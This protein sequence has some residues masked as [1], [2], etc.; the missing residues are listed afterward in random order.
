MIS[1][2]NIEDKIIN[3]SANKSLNCSK[4]KNFIPKKDFENSIHNLSI[5]NLAGV[6]KSNGSSHVNIPNQNLPLCQNA[7][8]INTDTSS[9]NNNN[10]NSL[11]DLNKLNN[12]N[13]QQIFFPMPLGSPT[14]DNIS[15]T[16]NPTQEIPLTLLNPSLNHNLNNLILPIT[17]NN[18]NMNLNM[19]MNTYNTFPNNNIITPNLPGFSQHLAALKSPRDDPNQLCLNQVNF[20]D[21]LKS[22]RD[23]SN[24]IN[25]NPINFD[26]SLKSPMNNL[27]IPYPEQSF[28]TQRNTSI[29]NSLSISPQKKDNSN[30]EKSPASLN[31]ALAPAMSNEQEGESSINENNIAQN[32][33][34]ILPNF[35]DQRAFIDQFN[36]MNLNQNY[37]SFS[38]IKNMN[39]SINDLVANCYILAKEQFGCRLLQKIIDENPTNASSIFYYKIKDKFVE[40]SCELFGNYFIQKI[41]ENLPMQDIEEILKK[42]IPNFFRLLSM[43]QHGTR[44]IQALLK[45]IKKNDSLLGFFSLYL[46]PSLS[47]FIFNQ[48]A[49]HVISNFV[50]CT[51][52][53]QNDVIFEFIKNNIVEISIQKHSCCVLQRCIQ[54]GHPSQI[55]ILLLAIAQNSDKLFENQFGNY[56]I[57]YV[58]SLNNVEINKII[59][60]ELLKNFELYS[61]MKYS[62]SIIEKCM[63]Y[64]DM[65]MKKIILE[66]ICNDSNLVRSLLYD[67]YGNYVI[68]RALRIAPEPYKNILLGLIGKHLGGL[69]M[70][71]YGNKLYLKLTKNYPELLKY[72][73]S[74]ESSSGWGQQ[75]NSN[76]FMIPQMLNNFGKNGNMNYQGGLGNFYGNNY[77]QAMNLQSQN[78]SPNMTPKMSGG[79]LGYYNQMNA[80]YMMNNYQNGNM[81]GGI[82]LM[83]EET[84][85]KMLYGKL[86]Y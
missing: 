56:V 48:N 46:A 81:N 68:Q 32:T 13:P 58:I 30:V 51:N 76:Q 8:N 35:I 61:K 52:P 70:L 45:R 73:S 15:P 31:I 57:Q 33:Q 66:K 78:I 37:S 67:M 20:T 83:N 41:I 64:A 36:S 63:Q 12:L 23:N 62:S 43:N 39:Y 44:V 25:I 5:N 16:Q 38:Q 71:S 7:F 19:N 10:S 72:S 49:N 84:F 50:S 26:E 21:A 47:T 17:S 74:K 77:S 42:I 80:N 54:S 14:P 65:D 60:N 3:L 75:G 6:N 55:Q 24:N 9:N 79:N 69:K 11:K 29:T 2:D 18:Q 86:N 34:N 59:L 1:D 82:N 28:K 40:L 4:S 27:N 85:K 22:P 53:K